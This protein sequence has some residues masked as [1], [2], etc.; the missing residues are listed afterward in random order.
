M[1]QLVRKASKVSV[2]GSAP[3]LTVDRL[4]VWSLIY[5]VAFRCP[6]R[7]D[8]LSDSSSPVCKPYLTARAHISPYVSPYYDSYLAPYAAQLQP[9]AELVKTKAVDPAIQYGQETYAL[10]AAPR[11]D[12]ARDYGREQWEKTFKPQLNAA[13]AQAKRQYDS[14]VAPHVEKASAAAAPYYSA[15]RQKV[16]EAYNDRVVPAYEASQPYVQRVYVSGNAVVTQYAYPYASWVWTSSSTFLNRTVWPKLQILYGENVEPQLLRISERLGRYRD[17]RKLKAAANEGVEEAVSAMTGTSASTDAAEHV[18]TSQQSTPTAKPKT[19]EEE[20]K[21]QR[22]Q[23]NNDLIKWKEKFAKAADKGTEDLKVRVQK[24]TERQ[25]ATN[26]LGVGDAHLVQLEEVISTET[27][28]FKEAISS[29]TQTLTLASGHDEVQ[30]AEDKVAQ[31]VKDAGLAIKTKAQTLRTWK[32]GFV[33]DTEAEITKAAASTLDVLDSIRDLGLQEIGMRWAWTDGV[34]YQDWE[35]YHELRQTFDTWRGK[36][37]AV[38]AEHPGLEAVKQA[39]DEIQAKGMAVAEEAAKEL[40]RLKQVGLWK[41][42]AIDQSDDFTTRTMP[43][44]AIL[45]KKKAAELARIESLNAAAAAASGKAAEGLSS[46]SS[47][48]IGTETGV[49]QSVS[50]RVVEAASKV[51]QRLKDDVVSPVSGVVAG[52]STPATEAAASSAS[53]VLADASSAVNDLPG[54]A[55]DAA[56]TV[57]KK[58]D[59]VASEA[60]KTASHAYKAASKS[61]E[62]VAGKSTPAHESVL[63]EAS[64]SFE[65]V[66]SAASSHASAASSKVFAGAMAQEVPKRQIILD[67]DVDDDAP[68]MEMLQ[69]FMDQAADVTKAV[70]EA[71][72][73]STSQGTVE[74]ATAAA[75]DQYAKALAAASTALYGPEPALSEKMSSAAADRYAQAFT[76]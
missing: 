19:P 49:A 29:A 30:E 22:E 75:K 25:S 3:K 7:L 69:K 53:S 65:S 16:E 62:S 20:E 33:N 28:K 17:G 50:T 41:V 46:A 18:K 15:G 58:V 13:Q 34:T 8:E 14:A 74:S 31:A 56:S 5:T 32:L 54:Q 57:S 63:S 27:S 39:A 1:V 11:V 2:I 4:L 68:H 76:A 48:I 12:Q 64:E 9:Y 6:A 52:S 23:I 36:V 45:A 66:G 42:K 72:Q 70:K 21:E 59:E 44:E 51:Q 10:Y 71:M 37:E 24:I 35:R 47:V 55:G 38:A 40:S 61:A 60:S 67:S 43:A 26:V 73:T